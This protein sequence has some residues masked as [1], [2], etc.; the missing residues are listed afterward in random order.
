[1]LIRWGERLREQNIAGEKPWF[2]VAFSGCCLKCTYFVL[3]GKMILY[4]GKNI[5]CT[6]EGHCISHR[7]RMESF[8]WKKTVSSAKSLR[9]APVWQNSCG[10]HTFSI[11]NLSPPW[12]YLTGE[13]G[14][15]HWTGPDQLFSPFIFWALPG[16]WGECVLIYGFPCDKRDFP[17]QETGVGRD[18]RFFHLC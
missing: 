13:F 11:I 8:L 9:S 18:L 4:Y 2:R 12:T 6:L 10:E 5:I 16:W 3:M 14:R 1:M 7:R 17:P 15:R